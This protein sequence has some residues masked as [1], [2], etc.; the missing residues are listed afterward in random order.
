VACGGLSR[1]ESQVH[2]GLVAG[3]PE[4]VRRV[5]SLKPARACTNWG[6][7]YR[8]RLVFSRKL[9]WTMTC[10]RGAREI[11][12]APLSCSTRTMTSQSYPIPA[13]RCVDAISD[14]PADGT[15]MDLDPEQV[16]EDGCPWFESRSASETMSNGFE[17]MS[18]R[19]WKRSSFNMKQPRP[20]EATRSRSRSVRMTS[21]AQELVTIHPPR[22]WTS[23][24]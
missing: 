15:S 3:G 6:T 19:S 22:S 13:C 5:S 11:S 4:N 2:R 14:H 18:G 12:L 20:G 1:Q 17:I 24:C 8:L 7:G 16:D 21:A 10:E 9:V 23:I